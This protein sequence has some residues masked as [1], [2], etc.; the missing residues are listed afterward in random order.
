LKQPAQGECRKSN[1]E[2]LGS[3]RDFTGSKLPPAK[4][5][6][7]S[8]IAVMGKIFSVLE[9]FVEDGTNQGLHFSEIAR[10][11]PFSR[12]TVHRI[13]YSLGKLGYIEKREIGS[14]YRLT[15]KFHDLATQRVH[16]RHLQTVSKP[17]MQTLLIRHAETVNLGTLDNGQ[18]AY[19]DVVQS[20]TAPSIA[21]FPGDRNPAHSTALGKAML[22]FMPESKADAILGERLARK[23]ARTITQKEHFLDHLSS[24][25]DQ[26]V[27][28]DMEENVTGV[29]CVAAP[30]FDPRG[31]VIAACSVSGPANRMIGKL[32]AVK[33]DVRAAASGITRMLPR[34]WE[35]RPQAEVK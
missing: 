12:T 16:F 11:L 32:H 22:A 17:F 33:M 26:R 15:R 3:Q 19:I 31:R 13:L 6:D 9:C 7:K 14:S 8:Y 4:Q 5:V 27:A 1:W 2:T 34:D 25:R 30:I 10:D 21:A 23:T 20:P 35:L 18:V 29:N 28:L 24:V